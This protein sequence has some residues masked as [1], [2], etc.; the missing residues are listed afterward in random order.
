MTYQSTNALVERLKQYIAWIHSDTK[1][2]VED[3]QAMNGLLE[4]LLS[5]L[6]AK[7]REQIE[8]KADAA[9][10]EQQCEDARTLAL[11]KGAQV[12]ALTAERDKL[13]IQKEAAGWS[14][15]EDAPTLRT[16]NEKL[17]QER[18]ELDTALTVCQEDDLF[19]AHRHNRELVA[20]NTRYREALK[21]LVVKLD[22]CKPHINSAFLVQA[23]HGMEYKGPDCAS[24]LAAAKN[25]LASEDEKGK[26]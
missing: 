22:E 18:E 1:D 19:H 11:Q 17:K 6:E 25:A 8:L 7:D 21:N 9:S 23:M 20:S 12:A 13:L 16:E 14:W 10:W 2:G 5:G 15:P 26:L 4:D 24:E 3:M